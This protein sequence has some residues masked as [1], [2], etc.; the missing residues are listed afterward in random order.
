M[1]EK[2]VKINFLLL[3]N[4]FDGKIM[5]DNDVNCDN[6]RRNY[7]IG[8]IGTITSY[9]DFDLLE[10]SLEGLIILNYHIIGPL[11]EV[12]LDLNKKNKIL[13]ADR[14]WKTVRLYS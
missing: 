3:I 4:A 5:D 14:T 7:I 1:N 9:F 2:N 8:Y 11:D 12:N 6:K 13:R 10:N